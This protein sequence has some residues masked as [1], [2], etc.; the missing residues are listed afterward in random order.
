MTEENF[1]MSEI[2]NL[3]AAV[4][5]NIHSQMGEDGVIAAIC[6]ALDISNGTAVEF[7][8]WDGVHLSNTA[9]LREAGWE[10]CLIEGDADR[11]ATLS[12]KFIGS[13]NVVPVQAWVQPDGDSTL[14]S[15]LARHFPKPVDLLSIDIDGDDYHIFASLT[16]RPRIIVIEIN[17]TIPPFVDRVNPRG[18]SKGSSLAALARLTNQKGYDLVHATMLNAFFVDRARNGRIQPKTPFEVFRWDFVRFVISDFD[19]ENWFSD[20][21][22]KQ[23]RI[24]NPW[25]QL[26]AAFTITYPLE[27]LGYGAKAVDRQRFV[28]ANMKT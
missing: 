14:D 24:M 26:P 17:P 25:D 12:K 15:L 18:Q 22:Q 7:G 8:A 11:F 21:T 27:L 16:T 6:R 5:H 20:I 1:R 23:A 3:S 28:L 4:E 19:G 2:V 13:R 9:A 10:T